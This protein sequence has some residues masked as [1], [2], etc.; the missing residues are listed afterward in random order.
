MVPALQQDLGP[1]Q[2]QCFL[3]FCGQLLPAQHIGFTMAGRPEKR[4]ETAPAHADIGIV[5]VA[6]DNVGNNRLGMLFQPHAM[7]HRRPAS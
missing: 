6:V 2:P 5:D 7:G 4:A 1:A 3:D